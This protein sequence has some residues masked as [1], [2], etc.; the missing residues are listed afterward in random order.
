MCLCACACACARVCVC[1]S[2]S[3]KMCVR[4]MYIRTY[5]KERGMKQMN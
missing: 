3:V 4:Q 5:E 2:R 1:V